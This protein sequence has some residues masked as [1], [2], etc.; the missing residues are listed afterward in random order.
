MSFKLSATRN[1]DLFELC[2]FNRDVSKIKSLKESMKKHG[3]IPAYPLHCIRNGNGKML[4]K[5]GHHR[6]EVAMMLGLAVFYVVS[7]DV[8]TIDELERATVPWNLTNYVTSF[9]KTGSQDHAAV[10]DFAN[11]TGIGVGQAASLMRGES[12]TS[13]NCH[14]KLKDGT[15]TVGDTAH[16][17]KIGAVI[18]KCRGMKIPFATHR[19]FVGA[20]SLCC[21]LDEFDCE[22]F[23]HR[24]ALNSGMAKP[25]P[26]VEAF[27]GMI[28]EVYNRQARKK[29]ALAFLAREAARARSVIGKAKAK[30]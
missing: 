17:E 6:F 28:E 18:V 10:A 27:L 15:Y 24:L 16:A 3:F 4:I 7:D 8:A 23:L 14:K 21:R 30:K 20:V 11:R 25:Q 9:V 2:P 29:I 19:N 26:T 1:Y 22:T 13:G 12:G 5:A